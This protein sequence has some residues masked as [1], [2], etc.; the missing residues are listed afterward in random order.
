MDETFELK[1]FDDGVMVKAVLSSG[2]RRFPDKLMGAMA[3]TVRHRH[4]AIYESWV[5]LMNDLLSREIVAQGGVITHVE[6]TVLPK[7]G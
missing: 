5:S 3:S 2:N 7:P 4:A 1:F 6:D